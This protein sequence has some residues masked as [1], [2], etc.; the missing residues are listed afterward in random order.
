[1]RTVHYI[2]ASSFLLAAIIPISM[3]GYLLA[4]DYEDLFYL[5]EGALIVLI[6]GAGAMALTGA[7]Q[8]DSRIRWVLLSV[9][10][11]CVHFSVLGL[12]LGHFSIYPMFWVYYLVTV[13]ALLVYVYTL[14]KVKQYRSV[15]VFLMIGSS[16]MTFYM[17]FLHMLW[18]ANLT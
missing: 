7:V 4:V 9:L 2:R 13:L 16:L 5:Y 12:F 18:G 14:F 15:P 3:I 17:M 6:A 1:M 10:A 8:T 11:F